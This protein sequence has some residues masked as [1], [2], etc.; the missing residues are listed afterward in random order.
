MTIIRLHNLTVLS[1][2]QAM[3]SLT[4]CFCG[5]SSARW[6]L[7]WSRVVKCKGL[8]SLIRSGVLMP[9]YFAR[10]SCTFVFRCWWNYIRSRWLFELQISGHMGQEESSAMWKI[11]QLERGYFLKEKPEVFLYGI[12]SIFILLAHKYAKESIFML[13]FITSKVKVYVTMYIYIWK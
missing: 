10:R 2:K 13:Q 3:N 11:G 9:L 1:V 4:I 8:C 6:F 12:C 7:T 5:F